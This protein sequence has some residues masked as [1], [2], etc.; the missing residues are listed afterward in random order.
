MFAI[1]KIGVLKSQIK[2]LEIE[3]EKS[4]SKLIANMKENNEMEVTG[5]TYKGTLVPTT[6]LQVDTEALLQVIG[7]ERFLKVVKPSVKEVRIE[8]SSVE[9]EACS[10]EVPGQDRFCVKLK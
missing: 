2:V 6:T 5:K 4:Q 3:I 1:D 9:L 10:V 7:Q 8:L